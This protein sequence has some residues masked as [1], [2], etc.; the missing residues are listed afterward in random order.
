MAGYSLEDKPV[1][2]RRHD[3]CEDCK[4]K[5]ASFGFLD[6]RK[7]RWCG[8]CSTAHPGA[9]PLKFSA[10]EDC[11]LKTANFG[12]QDTRKRRWCAAC[13]ASHPGARLLSSNTSRPRRPR[14]PAEPLPALD[15]LSNVA[16][17]ASSAA[18]KKQV[19]QPSVARQQQQQP[20]SSPPNESAEE[21]YLRAKT[22]RK[23]QRDKTMARRLYLKEEAR[24]LALRE[25]EALRVSRWPPIAGNWRPAAVD[26]R[27]RRLGSDGRALLGLS[28]GTND[29]E[30]HPARRRLV[31]V[32]V[33][34]AA[35]STSTAAAAGG[36][37]VGAGAAGAAAAAAAGDTMYEPSCKVCCDGC[38]IC[39]RRGQRGHLSATPPSLATA[40]ATATAAA[41]D[42]GGGAAAGNGH[43][44]GIERES[45]AVVVVGRRGGR[46]QPQ[47]DEG[48]EAAKSKVPS[49]SALRALNR[50]GLERKRKLRLAAAPEP[51]SESDAVELRLRMNQGCAAAIA[52][53][54]TAS[55]GGVED[56]EELYH[57]PS[58]LAMRLVRSMAALLPPPDGSDT[59]TGG[60]GP[61]SATR[62]SGSG[63]GNDSGSAGSDG[64]WLSQH[65]VAAM[66]VFIEEHIDARL[67]HDL[68]VQA[69]TPLTAPTPAAAS[70]QAIVGAASAAA[71]AP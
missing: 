10:C 36:G 1:A 27:K 15:A 29:D 5:T 24:L 49:P 30:Q 57:P 65:E 9:R 61:A 37:A 4:L 44:S 20:S 19:E 52:T 34:E 13:S 32:E 40:T 23:L 53:G 62:P 43:E 42:A 67:R 7:R 48:G 69:P 58:R 3:V 16:S 60:G 18:E 63:T 38:G 31:T 2:K 33:V 55:S 56:T 39:W 28:G 11:Q 21:A 8:A 26:R 22:Q 45:P 17:A 51:L 71:A 6:T 59:G 14:E 70:G 68:L 46:L 12:F 64:G 50:A 25:L 35:D 54:T 47:Q 41:G 66:A